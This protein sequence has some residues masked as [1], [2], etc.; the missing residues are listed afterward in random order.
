MW[1]ILYLNYFLLFI[2]IC[3]TVLLQDSPLPLTRPLCFP[4][5]FVLEDEPCIHPEKLQ[6]QPDRRNSRVAFA[7]NFRRLWFPIKWYHVSK[8]PR[9]DRGE[10]KRVLRTIFVLC[11]VPVLLE[12]RE[13]SGTSPALKGSSS[14]LLF[15]LVGFV[16]TN[17]HWPSPVLTVLCFRSLSVPLSSFSPFTFSHGVSW[18]FQRGISPFCS[19]IPC[20]GLMIK[21]MAPS[22]TSA[23]TMN[24]ANV[25]DTRDMK[26]SQEPLH[27]ESSEQNKCK[28]K[29]FLKRNAFVLLTIAAILIGK[30]P[31]ETQSVRY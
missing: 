28:V 12:K 2:C 11:T 22:A 1:Q 27:M 5:V 20:L 29:G 7:T 8:S 25:T 19:F 26:S 31:H 3:K 30:S 13:I 9:G 23:S 10:R 21:K 6:N 17:I 16:Q 4:E 18:L 14:C 24:D 15:F